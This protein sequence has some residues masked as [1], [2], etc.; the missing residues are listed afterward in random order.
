MPNRHTIFDVASSLADSARGEP[1]ARWLGGGLAALGVAAYAAYVLLTQRAWLPKTRPHP[2]G[3]A[4]WTG[5]SAVA[6]GCAYL[7]IAGFIHF[8]WFW[9]GDPRWHAVGYFGKLLSAAGLIAAI[10]W[11][12]YL[13]LWWG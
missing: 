4:E 13:E 5:A 12:L 3:W 8:H 11:L 2:P 7:A 10:A 1:A 6:L 9:S